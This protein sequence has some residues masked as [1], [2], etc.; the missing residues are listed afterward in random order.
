MGQV[1][2]GV[3]MEA[4]NGIVAV[5]GA[6]IGFGTPRSVDCSVRSWIGMGCMDSTWYLTVP[7]ELFEA[8]NVVVPGTAAAA[9]VAIATVVARMK[10]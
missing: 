10:E 9:A 7:G 6:G 2:A 1:V 5:L 3:G 8:A 4:V